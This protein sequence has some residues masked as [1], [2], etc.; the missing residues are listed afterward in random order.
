[1]TNQLSLWLGGFLLIAIGAD[2][3]VFDWD[4]TIFLSKKFL[5]FMEWIAFWR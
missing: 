2:A 4:N 3:L 1:M 5:E